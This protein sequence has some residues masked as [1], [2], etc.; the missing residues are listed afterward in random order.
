[1]DFSFSSVIF[2]ILAFISE[3]VGTISGF[4]SSVFFVPLAGLFFDLKTTLIL[5]ALLHIFSTSAQ[6]FLFR[7]EINWRILILL[8]IPSLIFVTIGA[9]LSNTGE[10]KYTKLVMGFF[11]VGFSLFSFY[12][13]N[14]QLK[15][16]NTNGILGGAVSGFLTGLI[17][18]GGAIRGA[19]LASFNLSKGAF[20][21]TSAAI[22]FT[23][24]LSRALIYIKNDYLE[25]RYYWYLPVLLIMAYAGVFTG[26][27]ILSYFSQEMFR[28]TVLVFLFS[29]GCYMIYNSITQY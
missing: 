4:G 23:G 10:F 25:F 20:I 8:G 29:I 17:G 2:F 28:K 7:K 16:S 22:D 19:T 15:Q 13:K 12:K 6:L 9:S 14:F 11:L 1:M 26:K 5:T 21:S 27:R 24:D 3:A 18:T